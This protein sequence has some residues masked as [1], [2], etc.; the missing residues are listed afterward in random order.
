[1]HMSMS[2][3]HIH[4][5]KAGGQKDY[6]ADLK[7]FTFNIVKSFQKFVF[8]RQSFCLFVSVLIFL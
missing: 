6:H 7:R 2:S 4:I 1:M 8:Q 5:H 3:V